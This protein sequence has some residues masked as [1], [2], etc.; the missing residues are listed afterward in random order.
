VITGSPHSTFGSFLLCALATIGC[1]SIPRGAAAVDGVGVEGNHAISD[2]DIEDKLATT[3]SER[4][5]SIAPRGFVY[6]YSLFDQ[7]VLQRD[8]ERVERLYHAKGYYDAH[9]RAGRVVYSGDKHV[10]ITIEVDEGKPTKIA[11]VDVFGL[12]T[13][14]AKDEKLARAAIGSGIEVGKN[15]DEEALKKAE[16]AL[17]KALTDHGYAFAKVSRSADVDL[18]GHYAAVALRV[19]AGP[20]CVFGPMTILGLG[21]LPEAPVRVAI[22]VKEGSEYSTATLDGAKQAVLDLG[23]FSAVEIEPVLSDRPPRDRVVPLKVTVQPSKLHAVILGGGVEFDP[24]KSEI[25]LHVGWEHKNLFG[26]FRHFQVDFKPGAVL[27]PTRLPDIQPP[28]TL[29]PEEMFKA[30]LRQPGFI[31][32]RTT[33]FVRGEANI[34][35]VLLTPQVD[36]TAPVLGW[37]EFKGGAGVERTFHKLMLT[38]SYDV[39]FDDPFAYIGAKDKDLTPITASYGEIVLQLDYRN[40]K[41]KPYK[42]VLIQNDLQVAGLGGNALDVRLQP[43]LRGYIP[44]SKRATLALRG[45]TGLL[46]AG[47]YGK[48][49]TQY[50]GNAPPDDLR[51]RWVE[52]IELFYL[53]GFVS[54]GPSSNRGYPLRGVGP[55]GIV[56]FFNPGVAASQVAAGCGDVTSGNPSQEA[57]CAVP[58]G[59]QTLWES[60]IELRLQITGPLGGALF[61]DAS[62]VE[63]DQV[64]FKF[65]HPH[66]SC[67]LGARYD[68]PI[69][70]VRL[71]VGYRIPGMQ[72]IGEPFD[73]RTEG[74]PGTVF[75]APLAF[76]FGIGEAF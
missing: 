61:C 64:T 52:D 46:F 18:P 31:E 42:G 49:L 11:R 48:T 5:L 4:L 47:N 27:Y 70:P 63:L 36:P 28:R 43:E 16:E 72:V 24:I 25:H 56:P 21:K 41:T 71:D 26:G 22:D 9:A 69:G 19:D 8:L 45:T 17:K 2:G 65:N 7:H 13:L 75:G 37:E 73:V 74:D 3:P 55:H 51:A 60:S 29:L 68:T 62:D 38:P 67:G 59:G 32:A 50:G 33:G 20:K 10:E 30:E 66:L 15:V 76:S 54:G 44:L 40:D 57:R 34:Y 6:D 53:R 39:Q 23:T 58:L 14:P 35:P 1:A 12:E